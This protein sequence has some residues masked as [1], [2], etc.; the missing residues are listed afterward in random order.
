MDFSGYPTG[1]SLA[2]AE[3]PLNARRPPAV[4]RAPRI[5]IVKRDKIGDLLLA[6]PMLRVL[7]EARPDARIDLL[8]SDYNAWL[9]RGNPDIDTVWTYRRARIGPRISVLGGL[10]QAALMARLR[11]LRYDVAI[12]AGGEISPRASRRALLA[13]ARRTIAY[14]GEDGPLVS[15]PL[16]A[17]RV[18]HE[19]E[20]MLGL[21]APLGID[22]PAQPPLPRFDPPRA[23]LDAAL[24]WLGARGL[25]PGRYV[26]MGLGARRVERRPQAAQVLRWSEALHRELGLATVLV[27]TPGRSDNPVYPGD[28][29]LAEPIV[30]AAPAHLHPF[31]GDLLPT[32]ALLWH[33]RTSMFPDSGLMHLAAASPGGVLGLFARTNVSPPPSQWAPLGTHADWIDAGDS[34]AEV[35]DAAVMPRLAALASRAGADSTPGRCTS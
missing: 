5:L 7:R 10:H 20:R 23:A 19:R 33:A 29:D 35:D 31:R 11:L 30:A 8:A 6:T 17:P 13:G 26:V 24:E 28:D 1:D 22:V 2:A 9:A 3:F 16:P 32:V 18:G 25:A 34:V 14:S 21:L 27:W 15:D 4:D 12:A